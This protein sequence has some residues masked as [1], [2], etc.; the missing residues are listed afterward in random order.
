MK[1]T[2]D[3]GT[4]ES[5]IETPKQGTA[6]I[7]SFKRLVD[8]VFVRAEEINCDEKVTHLTIDFDRGVIDYWVEKK[9]ADSDKRGKAND[10]HHKR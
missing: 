6:G 2:Y 8:D 10:P 3:M 7:I 1:I 9:D 5:A 4:C